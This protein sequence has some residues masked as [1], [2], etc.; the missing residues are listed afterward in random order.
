MK[1]K[2][3]LNQRVKVKH[4]LGLSKIGKIVQIRCTYV[5]KHDDG[6]AFAYS[7]ENIEKEN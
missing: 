3:D 4:S 7:E 1:T 2:Y 6:M 5:I